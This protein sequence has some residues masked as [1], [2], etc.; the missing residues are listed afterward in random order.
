M[1]AKINSSALCGINSFIVEVEADISNALPAFDIVGLPDA[2]VKESKERIRSAIKNTGLSMP[3]K[4]IIIN[5]AP[6]SVKK[7][8]ALYD[9]PI[10]A[11]I[12]I[13]SDQLRTSDTNEYIFLGELALDGTLRPVHGVL[14]M[15]ISAYQN[16]FK[17]VILPFE[18]AR[19]AAIID[20]M[21]VYGAKTLLEVIKHISGEEILPKTNVCA[22]ELFSRGDEYPFDFADVKGQESIKRALE[23]AAAGGHNIAM[24]GPPGSGKTMLAKRVPGIL[25]DMSFDEAL[26]VTKIHSISGA[27]PENVPM[28]TNR[29]FRSPHHTVSSVGLS[30]GGTNPRP[31]EV[32]LAHNGVL[33][34]DELPEFRRDALEILRQPLEDR[35]ITITRAGGTYTYPC[36]FMLIASYNPCPCGY[37]GDPNHTC[38]CT[39]SQIAKYMN[40]ISGPL[41][42]RI[43]IQVQVPAVTFE[44]LEGRKTGETSAQIRNRVNKARKIQLERYKGT[45]I[46]SNSRLTPELMEKYCIPDAA[47]SKILKFAFESMGLSGRA[48]NRILKVSRTIADLAGCEDIKAEHISEAIQ[49][50]TPENNKPF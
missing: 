19:E 32:S 4:K 16:G 15:V 31:G 10:S 28:I 38:V 9:L 7:V 39:D 14:P 45:N 27:L 35:E 5:L 44:E 25:P 48:Y 21:E 12:L 33:F 2:A 1:L 11:A 23:I 18:N 46:Y 37:L 26:E 50:R 41:L 17:K 34:L 47:G 36:N 40:R 3:A 20:S 8:G 22:A 43:D 30:G 29:P 13:A 42:D 49:Y 6:A 24:S